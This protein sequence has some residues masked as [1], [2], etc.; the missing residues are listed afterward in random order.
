MIEEPKYEDTQRWKSYVYFAI[1]ILVLLIIVLL[2]KNSINGRN[3]VD[4]PQNPPD[5]IVVPNIVRAEPKK[6]ADGFPQELTLNSRTEIIGSYSASYP[7]SSAKQTTVE[8]ISSKNPEVNY[9]FYIKWAE[10][11]GWQIVNSSKS[12]LIFS[13]Y[14]KKTSEA[15]NITIR[16]SVK[17]GKSSEIIISYV[18]LNK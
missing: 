18:N 6:V 1:S 3:S 9:N 13:L 12:D 5:N 4:N 16:S 17:T 15:I 2:I 14:F 11:N 10:D 8:F 7:N